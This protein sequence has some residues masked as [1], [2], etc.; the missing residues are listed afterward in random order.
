VIVGSRDSEIKLY[1]QSQPIVVSGNTREGGALA[2]AR[3]IATKSSLVR[4]R[5]K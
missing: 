3:L 5:S 1:H 4:E 2:L